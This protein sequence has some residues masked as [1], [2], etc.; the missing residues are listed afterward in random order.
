MS[1]ML[2]FIHL[3]AFTPIEVMPEG[4][5]QIIQYSPVRWFVD[6][7]ESAWIGESIATFAAQLFFLLCVLAITG[8]IGRS[9]FRWE[10]AR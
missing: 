1:I 3:G 5:Q 4:I 8:L 6:A 9:L 7:A 10:P 2:I